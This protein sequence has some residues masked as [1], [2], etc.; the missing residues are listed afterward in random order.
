LSYLIRIDRAMT[1]FLRLKVLFLPIISVTLVV[2]MSNQRAWGYGDP[3]V[4]K[5]IINNP[6]PNAV[7]TDQFDSDFTKVRQAFINTSSYGRMMYFGAKAWT[8][9]NP[10]AAFIIAIFGIGSANFNSMSL[11]TGLN[12]YCEGFDNAS[13]NFI[14]ISVIPNAQSAVCTATNATSTAVLFYRSSY[15]CLLAALDFNTT[16]YGATMN[17]VALNQYNAL[18][19]APAIGGSIFADFHNYLY[20][21]IT[22][23]LIGLGVRWFISWRRRRFVPRSLAPSYQ[24]GAFNTN[25]Y[26]V[27]GTN[28]QAGF[29]YGTPPGGN[30]PYSYGAQGGSGFP[31]ADAEADQG[32]SSLKFSNQPTGPSNEVGWKDDLNSPYFKHYFDGT[33]YTHVVMWNGSEWVPYDQSQNLQS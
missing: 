27:Y 4:T 14:P 32:E 26:Y 6:F 29:S 16:V 10:N 22:L 17:E 20:I 28:P 12:A 3:Q 19:S 7:L 31:S 15:L 25:K 11:S 5:Y 13:I 9:P 23:T 18:S 24:T 8:L 1:K 33:K 2:F 21:S 30:S